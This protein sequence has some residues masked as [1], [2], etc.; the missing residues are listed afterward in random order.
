MCEAPQAD[1]EVE[2]G[3]PLAMVNPAFELSPVTSS[4][5][6]MDLPLAAA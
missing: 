4:A 2:L 1:M 6:P 5:R 3:V